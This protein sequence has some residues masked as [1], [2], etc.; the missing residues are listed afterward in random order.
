MWAPNLCCEERDCRLDITSIP[1]AQK[2]EL[3]RGMMKCPCLFFWQRL[4]QGFIPHCKKVVGGRLMATI[5]SGKLAM[6]FLIYSI[7]FF[8]IFSYTAK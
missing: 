3:G 4:Q 6:I 8:V 2:E 7:M 5:S 1:S